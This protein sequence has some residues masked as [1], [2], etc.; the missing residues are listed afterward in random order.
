MMEIPSETD[1]A[2]FESTFKP[3]Y[4]V[5]ISNY[6]DR[7]IEI[8]NIFKSEI[9]EHPFPRSEMNIRAYSI[10]R[11]AAIGVDSA[12]AFVLVKAIE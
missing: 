10:I 6:I 1:F 4:Y 7:K 3:N 11:G 2:F 9:L 5:D 8:A 12:E